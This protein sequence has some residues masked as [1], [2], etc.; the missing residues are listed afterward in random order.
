MWYTLF[1]ESYKQKEKI[2]A[3]AVLQQQEALAGISQHGFGN[4]AAV[5]GMMK[6]AWPH[7]FLEKAPQ[8]A[9]QNGI[10]LTGLDCLQLRYPNTPITLETR[11]TN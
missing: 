5:Q 7:G 2:K 3:S 6:L 8:G 11:V 1:C 10:E 9:E 4:P